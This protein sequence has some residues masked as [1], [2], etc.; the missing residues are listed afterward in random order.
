[1]DSLDPYIYT[2]FEEG[3]S[4]VI[5]LLQIEAGDPEDKV[6]G[7]LVN[8]TFKNDGSYGQTSPVHIEGQTVEYEAVS[9]AQRLQLPILTYACLCLPNPFLCL[10]KI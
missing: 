3:D 1:M 6:R 5:R 10:F 8:A 4:N 2:K 7:N 9:W